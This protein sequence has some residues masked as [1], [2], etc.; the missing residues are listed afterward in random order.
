MAPCWM[1][2]SFHHYQCLNIYTVRNVVCAHSIGEM[3][4]MFAWMEILVAD[5]VHDSHTT[6]AEHFVRIKLL[7]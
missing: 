5:C 7:L 6:T 3:T 1:M 4:H 2:P